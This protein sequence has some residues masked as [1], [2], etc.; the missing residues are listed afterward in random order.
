[1][2]WPKGIEAGG[3]GAI[4]EG[5]SCSRLFSRLSMQLD[6][7]VSWL[8]VYRKER[9]VGVSGYL[10]VLWLQ[11]SGKNLAQPPMTPCLPANC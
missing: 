6:L 2:R 4:V 5:W 3:G 1:M 11:S 7:V 9:S 8:K 10:V